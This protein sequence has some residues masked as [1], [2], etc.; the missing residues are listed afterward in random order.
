MAS[1]PAEAADAE[2]TRAALRHAL[3]SA[4]KRRDSEAVAALR[5]AM[6]A[7]GNAEAVPVPVPETDPVPAGAGIA[8]ARAGVG[9][10]EA[11]RR[12]LSGDDIRAILRDQIAEYTR[13][14]DRYE[15]HGQP[16]AAQRLRKRADALARQLPA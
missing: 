12:R 13:E 10:T 16:D 2:V 6:A 5:I 15:E 1:E 7:I 8:A 9:S 3:T 4:M 11:A 14:A